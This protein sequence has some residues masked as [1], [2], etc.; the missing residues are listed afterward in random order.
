MTEARLI[1]PYAGS[2]ERPKPLLELRALAPYAGEITVTALKLNGYEHPKFEVAVRWVGPPL[3][4]APPAREGQLV[5]AN[6]NLV[7]DDE[8]QAREV[9]HRARNSLARGELP[10]LWVISGQLRGCSA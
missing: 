2:I 5:H 8:Q 3:P 10:D 6:D 1:R 7:L 9:A 4:G